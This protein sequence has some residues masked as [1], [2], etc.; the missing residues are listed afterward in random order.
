[1]GL[2]ARN[3]QGNEVGG[4][5]V[6]DEQVSKVKTDYIREAT[7]DNIF[8]ERDY[9]KIKPQNNNPRING[10]IV[11]SKEYVSEIVSGFTSLYQWI[12]DNKTNYIKKVLSLFNGKEAR[13]I[14]RPTLFYSQ[15]MRISLNPEFLRKKFEREIIFRRLYINSNEEDNEILKSELNDMKLGDIPYFT[16]YVGEKNV[17]NSN[18]KKLEKCDIEIFSLS[19]KDKVSKFN[20]IDLKEQTKYIYDSFISRKDQSDQTNIYFKTYYNK[21]KPEK[22]LNTAK[23]IGDLIIDNAIEGVNEKKNRDLSWISVTMQGFEEDVWLPSVLNDDLYS[24]NAG[25]SLFL[26][27]LWHLTGRKYYL[28]YSK[29]AIETS[30]A[31]LE[32]K[33][34]SKNSDVGAFI[35]VGGTLYSLF[36]LASVT[37]DY[38][39]KQ[40]IFDTILKLES[41]IEFDKTNDV[42][43][44]NA[45]LLAVILKMV[46]NDPM[47]VDI[48]IKNIIQK[49]V[50]K[51]LK[52]SK[53]TDTKR[54]WECIPGQSYCGFSHGNSGIHTYL[55]K[56]MKY[57]G[58]TRVNRIINE[59]LNYEKCC[60]SMIDKDWY[61]NI[62]QKKI[63]Y[64]WCHGSPGILLSKLLLS[65]NGFYYDDLNKE[66]EISLNNTKKYGIG[67]NP[68]YCHGDLGNLSI[69]IL[70]SKLFKDTGIENKCHHIFQEL[71]ENILSKEWMNNK[72]KSTNNYGLMVGLSGW[73]YSMLSNYSKQEISNF[74]WLD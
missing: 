34:L 31:Q 21:L 54:Y 41:K 73:G 50:N 15:L 20:L 25:I 11:D 40:Y 7:N 16:F 48:K 8:I 29:Q 65:K 30:K 19:L 66:I 10:K 33:L 59:S 6:P 71:Y 14:F 22:W 70:A 28:N 2:R 60:Y 68:T 69:L 18:G 38:K 47:F 63:S 9:Y 46:D 12:I 44:G 26:T 58:D 57:I 62:E 49:I 43:G 27:T 17:F 42:I 23:N 55:Y 45:G 37:K 64:S 5:S 53:V 13:Y 36:E 1:M 74:L 24:G 35:G 72:Y 61:R 56:A 32:S 39:L 3:K 4:V 67:N 52:E 51:L